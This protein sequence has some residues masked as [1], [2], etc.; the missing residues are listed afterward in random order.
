MLLGLPSNTGR[1]ILIAFR[2][3]NHTSILPPTFVLGGGGR[4]RC[5]SP[6]SSSPYN[7]FS[8][9]FQRPLWLTFHIK[10]GSRCGFTIRKYRTL[11]PRYTLYPMGLQLLFKVSLN[12][13][14]SDKSKP[15]L[16]MFHCRKTQ[17]FRLLVRIHTYIALTLIIDFLV[18]EVRIERTTSG[19]SDQRSYL[20]ELPRHILGLRINSDRIMN[21]F[22]T[23]T[24]EEKK[25][26]F[27]I[28]FKCSVFCFFLF[29][30]IFV[31]VI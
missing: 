5:R 28:L 17:I 29:T 23:L 22:R 30:V 2:S 12:T 15:N 18:P 9:Q 26:K 13:Y 10:I 3:A 11:V 16:I 1:R 6:Y 31:R 7:L 20:T 27:F 8:R 24:T 21:I 14:H 19:F 4:L 25:I